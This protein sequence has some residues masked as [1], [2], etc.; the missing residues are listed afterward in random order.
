MTPNVIIKTMNDEMLPLTLGS[1]SYLF[2][3]LPVLQQAVSEN[4]AVT[5][6]C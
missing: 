5:K 3:D 2:F 6:W 1:I 4:G